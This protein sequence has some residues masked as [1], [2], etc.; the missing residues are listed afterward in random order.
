MKQHRTGRLTSLA[1]GLVMATLSV[2]CDPDLVAGIQGSGKTGVAAVGPVTGFGSIFVDGVEYSTSGAQISIDDASASESQLRVG[3][4]V[5]IKGEVN[6]D[7]VTGTATTVS[8]SSDVRG[9]ITQVDVDAGVFVVLG[10]TINVN[11]ATLFDEGF[12]P[13]D[14]SGIPADSL[15]QVSGFLDSGGELVASR[16]EPAQASAGLQVRGTVQALDTTAHTFR[17]NTL[18]VDYG[19]IAPT[20]TL[21][22]GAL[23]TIQGD[24]LNTSGSLTATRVK[25]FTGLGAG[26]ND[27]GEVEGVV[28][29]FTSNT[30][31]SVGGQAVTTNA[32]TQ[33]TPQGTVLGL[34]TRIK[35]HGTF[36]ASGVLVA[37]KIE[38]RP[39]SLSLVRGLVSSVSGTSLNVLGVSVTTSSVTAFEDKSSLHIR[40]FGLDDVRIGDYVEVR[41]AADTGSGLVAASLE[42]DNPENRSYLQGIARNVSSPSLTVLGVSVTTG[43]QTQFLGVGGPNAAQQFFANAPDQYVR[44]RGTLVGGTFLADQAQIRH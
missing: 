35:V 21:A 15:V 19:S 13:R 34:D 36:N 40:S 11:D 6:A 16:V 20:G 1:L 32:A 23:V 42:R 39:R 37:N 10:Q 27:R 22:N 44:V 7:G 31:F 41:G 33:I 24:S 8:F 28:T 3:H 38:V 25:V 2:G 4:V 43:V 18:T 29:S 17:I 14:L 26:A 9:K 12:S 5:A 30:N